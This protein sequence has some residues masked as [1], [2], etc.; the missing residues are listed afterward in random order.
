M[1]KEDGTEEWKYESLTDDS[2]LNSV[3]IWVFWI[4]LLAT[5]VVW[6]VFFVA[7]VL[8]FTAFW[9]MCTLVNLILAS[10]NVVGYY[11]CRKDHKQKLKGMLGQNAVKLAANIGL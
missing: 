6:V 11:R 5:P 10:T 4:A 8:T 2:K 1:I 3:D 7:N 9:A